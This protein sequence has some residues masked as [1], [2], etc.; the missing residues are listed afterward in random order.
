MGSDYEVK[1][2]VKDWFN[3]LVADSMMHAFRNS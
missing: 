3:E 1:K 2:T